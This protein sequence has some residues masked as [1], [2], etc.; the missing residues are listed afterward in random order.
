MLMVEELSPPGSPAAR[1][2]ETVGGYLTRLGEIGGG[3]LFA[4]VLAYLTIIGATWLMVLLMEGIDRLRSRR[5]RAQLRMQQMQEE[6]R[7]KIREEV[8]E[9]FRA[10]IR[11]E[12]REEFRAEMR[13]DIDDIVRE[14]L[15]QLGIATDTPPHRDTTAAAE[16]RPAN[17]APLAGH[18]S[19]GLTEENVRSVV[20]ECLLQLGIKPGQAPT[21]PAD[22]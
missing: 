8:R 3:A 2:G 22:G 6:F 7:A 11:E 9:E 18:G 1:L 15:A 14:R 17:G 10:N 21:T 13:E 5:A 19:A 4:V 20:R 12:M 16:P